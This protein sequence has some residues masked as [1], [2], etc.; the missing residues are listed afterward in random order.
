M[1]QSSE[2]AA[3]T[4]AREAATWFARMR[5]PD[6]DVRRGDFDGWL[7][8]GPE[9]RAAYNRAG[10]IFALGKLLADEPAIPPPSRAPRWRAPLATAMTCVLAVGIWFGVRPHETLPAHR[11]TAR[12]EAVRLLITEAGEERLARLEDGST[13]RL[14]GDS[15]LTVQFGPAKR[16][17]TLLHGSARFD[18]QHES[19]PFIVLAGGGSVTARGTLFD[20]AL[21]RPDKIEV[22]LLRGAIDVQLPLR[23]GGAYGAIRRL[24]AGESISYLVPPASKPAIPRPGLAVLEPAAGSADADVRDLNGVPVRMLLADANRETTR[25]IRL[26]D[27]SIGDERISGRLRVDDTARLARQLSAVF[28]WSIDAHDPREIVLKP[29]PKIISSATP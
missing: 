6:A 4:L 19:R 16:I 13:A 17:L 5:G 10:E 15:R 1:T 9:H 25:P 7:A 28:G 20:V 29:E 2:R 24:E 8:R 22:R 23:P 26:A 14:S 21:T 12:A 11:M 18:V 3:D 27:A